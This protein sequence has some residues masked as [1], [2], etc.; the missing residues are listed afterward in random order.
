MMRTT[1]LVV[2]GVLAGTLGLVGCGDDATSGGGSGG[3]AGSGGSGGVEAP[4]CGEGESIDASFTTAEGSVTC[5]GLDVIVVPIGVVLAAKPMGDVSADQATD[6]EVQVQFVI[7]ED[8]VAELGAFVQ[9]AEIS[10]SSSDVD[11]GDAVNAV[12]VPATVPCT[13]DFT[14]DPD[15]NGTAGPIVVTA[16]VVMAAWTAIDGSIVLQAAEMT[17]DIAR[18]VA[19]AL[20]TKDKDNGDP[21]DCTWITNPTLTFNVPVP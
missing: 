1:K 14:A 13:V 21:G 19:L 2:I 18:P 10:E 3:T 16:P 4:A 6:F 20:S 12:N 15:D 11:D 9:V 5:N 7:D 8:A 17:F